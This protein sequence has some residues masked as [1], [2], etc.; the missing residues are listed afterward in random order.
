MGSSDACWRN[1]LN[2]DAFL[3]VISG[4]AVNAGTA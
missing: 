2:L 1:V 3:I 4:V